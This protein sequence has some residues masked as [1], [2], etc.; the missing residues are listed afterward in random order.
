MSI[1][2][3]PIEIL[4]IIFSYLSLQ[5]QYIVKVT[6]SHRFLA[7]I[8]SIPRLGFADY[9]ATLRESLVGTFPKAS[10]LHSVDSVDVFIDAARRGHD[11]LV[12][13]ALKDKKSTAGFAQ[14]Y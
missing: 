8:N 10:P 5:E 4:M 14:C 12:T 1:N 7:A 3:L 13:A 11:S 6:G 2:L 9:I